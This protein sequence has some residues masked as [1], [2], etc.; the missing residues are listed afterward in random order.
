[1]VIFEAEEIRRG[2]AKLLL[3]DQKQKALESPGEKKPEVEE[4]SK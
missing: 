2:T 4:E 1:L 3:T